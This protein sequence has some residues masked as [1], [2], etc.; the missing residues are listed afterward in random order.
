MSSRAILPNFEIFSLLGAR[1]IITKITTA[2]IAIFLFV[3]LS[4]CSSN[5]KM[6]KDT[7][8]SLYTFVTVTVYSDS[9]IIAN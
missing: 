6:Y 1:G 8:I 5:K 9:N 2:A 3:F 4:S 7:R